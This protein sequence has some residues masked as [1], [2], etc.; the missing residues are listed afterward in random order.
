V[1]DIYF[2][3][4]CQFIGYSLF[5][6]F[7]LSGSQGIGPDKYDHSRVYEDYYERY[8]CSDDPKKPTS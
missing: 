4:Y 7:S 5:F 8:V 6:I 2:V 1:V 3:L